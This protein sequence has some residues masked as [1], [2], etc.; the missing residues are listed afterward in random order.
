M[1]MDVLIIMIYNYIKIPNTKAENLSQ[2]KHLRK[3]IN[4]FVRV[5]FQL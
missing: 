1:K 4:I 3:I 5:V 2:T